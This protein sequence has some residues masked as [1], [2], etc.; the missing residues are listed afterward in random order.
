MSPFAPAAVQDSAIV[1][2]NA[3]AALWGLSVND[4]VAELM[5]QMGCT[6]ALIAAARAHPSSEDVQASTAGAMRNL[7]VS[8]DSKHSIVENE[9]LEVLISATKNH[10]GSALVQAQVTSALRN[11]S[12]IDE[13]AEQISLSGG[14][15]A[16]ISVSQVRPVSH[17]LSHTSYV[18][19]RCSPG[20]H[21][22]LTGAPRQR[23]GAGGCC[24]RAA[25]PDDHRRD[26]T[27]DRARRRHRRAHQGLG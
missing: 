27:A 15:T 24:G 12:L 17:F 3:A 25:Q 10:T 8:D 18:G 14:I 5:V 2:A 21:L 7:A 22:C 1:A 16:L 26:R 4:D 11:L 19:L 20:A 6:E 23:E 13:I 9:G